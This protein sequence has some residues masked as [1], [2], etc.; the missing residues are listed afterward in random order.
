MNNSGC[1]KVRAS[2]RAA[3]KRGDACVTSSP[4]SH[5][6]PSLGRCRPESTPS[7]VDLPAPFGPTSP[8]MRPGSTSMDTLESAVSPPKRTVM[9]LAA[10]GR[11]RRRRWGRATRRCR[12]R[13]RS[14]RHTL[15]HSRRHAGLLPRQGVTRLVLDRAQAPG[16]AGAGCSRPA[17]RRGIWQPRWHRVRRGSRGDRSATWPT[18]ELEERGRE[19]EHDPGD[20]RG[21]RRAHPMVTSTASHTI[22]MNV[23]NSCW[24]E[25]W[26]GPWRRARRRW[27]PRRR[28]SEPTITFIWTTLMPEVRAPP[29]SS[30]RR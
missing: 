20:Q 25:R 13:G 16:C 2:P 21:G 19:D 14:R 4:R 23:K 15:G 5:T 11:S 9:P 6:A 12:C 24:A 29:R 8:A 27:R 3:R 30:V 10:R 1:W 28:P 18:A 7:R 22:P 26:S 17:R